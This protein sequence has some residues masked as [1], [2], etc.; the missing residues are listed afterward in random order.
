[1][2]KEFHVG[3]PNVDRAG[4]VLPRHVGKV[5]EDGRAVVDDARQ[6]LRVVIVN[7]REGQEG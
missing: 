7:L 4:V 2:A 6:A 5:E 1:L 3:V